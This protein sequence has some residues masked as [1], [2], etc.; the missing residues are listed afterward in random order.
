MDFGSKQFFQILYKRD[1]VQQSSVRF[2]IHQ[3]IEITPRI[4]I[5]GATEPK[6]R[7]F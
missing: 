6:T 3:E 7:T 1:M 5:A 2:P 4:G